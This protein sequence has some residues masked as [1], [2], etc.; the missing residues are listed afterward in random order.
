MLLAGALRPD[1]PFIRWAA[2]VSQ[3]VLAAFVVLAVVAPAGG[4]AGVPLPARLAGLAAGLLGG[5][6]LDRLRVHRR[7]LVEDRLHLRGGR[8]GRLDVAHRDLLLLV[9]SLDLFVDLTPNLFQILPSN[10]R[11]KLSVFAFLSVR[12]HLLRSI[13]IFLLLD[14]FLLGRAS[15]S[16]C[17]R[18]RP[19]LQ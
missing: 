1:H 16:W 7:E 4:L 18:F 12:I 19:M 2:A 15:L 14:L 9:E 5:E 17:L 11:Y 13:P 8:A 10:L 3:A 6:C